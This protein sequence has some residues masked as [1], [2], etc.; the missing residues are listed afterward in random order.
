MKI[1]LGTL[2]SVSTSL[3]K[4]LEQDLPIQKAFKLSRLA[5]QVQTELVDLEQS[6]I[7]LV[8]QY[9]N[10]DE[11]GNLKVPEDKL[12]DFG[13][14]FEDLLRTEISL[15]FDKVNLSDISDAKISPMDLAVLDDFVTED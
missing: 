10:E 4:L 5:K 1:T 7:K 6:R 15:E 8:K 2:K 3:R 9:G 12:K 13:K 14:E 11:S